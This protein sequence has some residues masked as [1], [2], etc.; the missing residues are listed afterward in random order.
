MER[1]N[2]RKRRRG[3]VASRIKLTEALY[4]SEIGT[5][6]ALAIK[7][8]DL[9]GISTPPKNLV[10]KVFQE[11][12][13]QLETLERIANALGTTT[14]SLLADG[15]DDLVWGLKDTEAT[16]SSVKVDEPRAPKSI[17]LPERKNGLPGRLS[18]FRAVNV[19]LI[20]I[21]ITAAV[22]IGA[23]KSWQFI[24]YAGAQGGPD[25][26]PIDFS[27]ASGTPVTG[28][29]ANNDVII[30]LST[31]NTEPF[32]YG[33]RDRLNTDPSYVTM[34]FSQPIS[35]FQINVSYVLKDYEFLSDFS[36]GLPS[37]VTGTLS[38][39]DGLVTS[40]IAGDNGY[41]SLIWNNL[42]TTRINFCICNLPDKEI[43]PAL[44]LESFSYEV[45]E[46]EVEV[47][48]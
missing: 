25:K 6:A 30:A 4:S 24:R 15:E 44:W 27:F 42:N 32:S 37:R 43:Y 23:F 1:L 28:F 46:K 36:M 39:V 35:S 41:G 17:T 11:Q 40:S 5:Q 3:V 29:L 47:V 9:E 45:V 7:I 12:S 22:A 33:L 8:A 31:S 16:Q 20:I 2:K 19:I 26:A 48:K 38:V 14:A 34:E 21:A 18:D 13:V 10:S